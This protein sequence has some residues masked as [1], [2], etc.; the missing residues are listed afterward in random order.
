MTALTEDQ[1]VTIAT[2]AMAAMISAEDGLEAILDESTRLNANP[3]TML[4]WQAF[5]LADAMMAEAASSPET[6]AAQAEAWRRRGDKGGYAQSSY[7]AKMIVQIDPVI[8]LLG[9]LVS[10]AAVLAW[11]LL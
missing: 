7:G 10:A 4:A 5:S 6:R 8:A 2:A 3:N 11:W 9:A 1:R